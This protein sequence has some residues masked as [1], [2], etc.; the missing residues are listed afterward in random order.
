MQHVTLAQVRAKAYAAYMQSKLQAQALALG[1]LPTPVYETENYEGRLCYCA[2]GPALNAETL[3]KIERYSWGGEP[4]TGLVLF[5]VVA[6]P[7]EE[8]GDI[9]EI[10]D[11]HDTW[12]TA[13]LTERELAE[14]EFLRLVRPAGFAP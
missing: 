8:I 11:A 9:Q 2:I 13:P 10:Q 7:T 4:F 1:D 12:C 3:L 14:A 6:C 5:G